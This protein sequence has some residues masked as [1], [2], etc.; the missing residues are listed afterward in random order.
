MNV[1]QRISVI[2]SFVVLTFVGQVKGQIVGFDILFANNISTEVGYDYLKAYQV[3]GSWE[4][5]DGENEFVAGDDYGATHILSASGSL[6]PPSLIPNHDAG[7]GDISYTEEGLS[8]QIGSNGMYDLESG[9]TG[10]FLQFTS[11]GST[12]RSGGIVTGIRL[13]DE[14]FNSIDVEFS[15]DFRN[16]GNRASLFSNLIRFSSVAKPRDATTP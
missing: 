15:F 10:I 4:G 2:C 12:T 9:A 11:D 8:F 14:E 1:L 7:N 3:K 13:F 5:G 16:Y 6:S